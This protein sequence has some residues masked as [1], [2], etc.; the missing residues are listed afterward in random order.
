MLNPI[1]FFNYKYIKKTNEK[2]EKPNEKFETA[3]Y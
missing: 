1:L 3:N 2:F